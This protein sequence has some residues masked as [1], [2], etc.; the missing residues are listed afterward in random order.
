[1][2]F[3]AVMEIVA[4]VG[5]VAA[6][7]FHRRKEPHRLSPHPEDR[8]ATTPIADLR[9]GAWSRVC[10]IVEAAGAPLTSPVGRQSCIGFRLLIERRALGESWS[11]VIKRQR[12][13]SF[14]I[15][16]DSGE[17]TVAGPFLFGL[18]VDDGAWAGLPSDVY[19]IL[20]KAKVRTS[21][22]GGSYE[23]RFSQALLKP[24]DRISILGRAK[25]QLDPSGASAGYRSPPVAWHFKGTTRR[26][27][28]L[29]DEDDPVT[30]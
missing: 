16:D 27:I 17:A 3:S 24:G 28:A 12:C 10:G 2:D 1:M 26:P 22:L 30:V 11:P 25:R 14:R 20:H 5:A 18:D 4:A 21:A 9:E 13:Q 7:V 23:F 19:E 8:A 15:R 29:T 6:Y